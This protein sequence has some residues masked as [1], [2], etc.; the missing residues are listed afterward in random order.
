MKKNT[1]ININN[2]IVIIHD[3]S[4]NNIVENFM[5]NANGEKKTETVANFGDRPT[6]LYYFQAY[7][8]T[9]ISSFEK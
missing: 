4:N 9:E 6:F 7:P 1:N 3:F 5:A 2:V 8:I